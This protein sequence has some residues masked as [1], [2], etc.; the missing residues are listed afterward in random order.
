[1][2]ARWEVL[3]K[4]RYSADSDYS[5]IVHRLEFRTIKGLR[6]YLKAIKRQSNP[7]VQVTHI[8]KKTKRVVDVVVEVP[9]E[10]FIK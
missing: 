6:F 1:M 7:E 9:L 5:P 8:R 10:R 3:Y 4:E 2:T